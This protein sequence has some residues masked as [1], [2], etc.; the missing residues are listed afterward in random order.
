MLE[1]EPHK[2]VEVM[3]TLSKRQR[4][5]F[6]QE[7]GS[8]P[9]SAISHDVSDGYVVVQFADERHSFYMRKTGRIAHKVTQKIF[10]DWNHKWVKSA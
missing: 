6:R 4:I 8:M 9:I 1:Q 5:A 3:N 2:I 10:N 7:F